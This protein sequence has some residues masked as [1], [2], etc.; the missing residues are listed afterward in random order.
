MIAGLDPRRTPGAP[1]PAPSTVCGVSQAIRAL[2]QP[3]PALRPQFGLSFRPSLATDGCSSRLPA[4]G[5][6]LPKWEAGVGFVDLRPVHSLVLW[7]EPMFLLKLNTGLPEVPWPEWLCILCRLVSLL[8]S[9]HSSSTSRLSDGG[10]ETVSS[11]Q[12]LLESLDTPWHGALSDRKLHK[13]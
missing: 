5:R 9:L 2:L 6:V 3:G 11:P 4:A 10:A 1:S 12:M 7:M 8:Q 13:K